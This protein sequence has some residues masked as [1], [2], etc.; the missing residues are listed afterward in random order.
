MCPHALRSRIGRGAI[1]E[2]VAVIVPTAIALA[3]EL[4]GSAADPFQPAYW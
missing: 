3:P 1:L 4:R 2:T